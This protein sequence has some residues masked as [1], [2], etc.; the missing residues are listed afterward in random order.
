MLRKWVWICLVVPC[1]LGGAGLAVYP[2]EHFVTPG[3]PVIYTATNGQERPLA[4][5]VSVE[6]WEISVDGEELR[7]PSED[8]V[9]FPSQFILKGKSSRRIKVGTR[10]REAVDKERA[11]RVTIQ[12]LPVSFELEKDDLSKVYMANAYRTSFYVQPADRKSTVAVTGGS[13][14]ESQLVVELTNSGNVHTH[15]REPILTL[16][17]R[18]GKQLVLENDDLLDPISGQNLHAGIS[19]RFRLDLKEKV[20]DPTEVTGGTLKLE[21]AQS[22]RTET[23]DLRL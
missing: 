22:G 7:K 6:E 16:A 14:E 5:Q 20:A 2:M 15:L 3:K 4:V 1:F 9:V 12:E 8:L 17:L 23:F 21:D 19:R 13:W 10:S 11:Y 18:D